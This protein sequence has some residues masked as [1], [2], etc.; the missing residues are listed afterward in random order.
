[1]RREVDISFLY[2]AILLVNSFVILPSN[3]IAVHAC[4][5]LMYVPVCVEHAYIHTYIQTDMHTYIHI[6][7]IHIYI[8]TYI[9]TYIQTYMRLKMNEYK[10]RT[11]YFLNFYSPTSGLWERQ[12]PVL[13]APQSLTVSESRDI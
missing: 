10:A 4:S 12:F 7:Y 6:T 2:F 1:M 13:P 3:I 11:R 8:H 9:H 5:L